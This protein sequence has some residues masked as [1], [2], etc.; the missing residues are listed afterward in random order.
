MP[1]LPPLCLAAT[2][3]LATPAAHAQAIANTRVDYAQ[4]LRVEPVYEIRSVQ[5]VD[6]E[7][8]RPNRP[9]PSIGTAI[10]ACKPRTTQVRAIVAY[11]VEYSYKGDVYMSRMKSDPGSRL[12]V[13]VSV[14]P[15]EDGRPASVAPSETR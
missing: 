14:A 15:I 11:D 4:V 6:P 9:R 8:L 7:C 12:R 13:R 10:D 1:R 2:L 3:A 5:A